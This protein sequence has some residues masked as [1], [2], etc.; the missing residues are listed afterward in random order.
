MCMH[1]NYDHLILFAGEVKQD[2]DGYVQRTI[3]ISCSFAKY[4]RLY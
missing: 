4:S 3:D 1:H 2:K